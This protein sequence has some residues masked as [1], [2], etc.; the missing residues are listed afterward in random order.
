MKISDCSLYLLLLFPIPS[1]ASIL[2][3][4]IYPRQTPDASLE[5]T[6]DTLLFS[7]SMADFL[8]ARASQ[9]PAELDWS[10]NGC[11]YSPEDPLGFDFEPSCQ[12]HDF[13]YRNYKAQGRFDD[14]GK[15]AIDDQ[16]REDMRAVCAEETL[17]KEVACKGV[18]EVYYRAV[19][20]FGSKERRAIEAVWA[21]GK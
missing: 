13:G 9:T 7:S 17:L 1:L 12:R 11:S 18:A 21:N 4:S 15:A 5:S 8:T 2:N 10:S 14:S 3:R 6:T 19:V 16:F 20:T